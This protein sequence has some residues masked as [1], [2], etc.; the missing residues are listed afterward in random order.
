MEFLTKEQIFLLQKE[1]ESLRKQTGWRKG[2]CLFNKLEEL[3]PE[4]A[5][6]IRGRGADPFYDDKR[7]PFF[8]ESIEEIDVDHHILRGLSED[9]SRAFILVVIVLG[10]CLLIYKCHFT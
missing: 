7:I 5:E 4:V 9:R 1:A 2:Q 6:F 10:L 8:L 3:F